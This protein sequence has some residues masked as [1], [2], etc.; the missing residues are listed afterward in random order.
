MLCRKKDQELVDCLFID[1][2]FYRLLKWCSIEN[3]WEMWPIKIDFGQPNAE[4][5]RKW[6]TADLCTYSV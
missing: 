6:P 2:I 3:V 1:G 5:V 4:L